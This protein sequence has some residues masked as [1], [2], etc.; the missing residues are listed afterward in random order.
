MV[1]VAQK[2]KLRK[3]ASIKR[4]S[5]TKFCL[6]YHQPGWPSAKVFTWRMKDP[7]LNPEI[8][9]NSLLDSF[10]SLSPSLQLYSLSTTL[11]RPYHAVALVIH[12]PLLVTRG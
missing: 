3:S 5:C 12:A 11:F 7:H 9:M 4:E 8:W 10:I 2:P 6:H 1:T